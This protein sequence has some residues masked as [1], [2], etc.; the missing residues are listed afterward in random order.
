VGRKMKDLIKKILKEADFGWMDEVPSD[1]DLTLYKFLSDNS[2]I[3]VQKIQGIDGQLKRIVFLFDDVY[4]VVSSYQNKNDAFW[5]IVNMLIDNIDDF[6][7]KG[8]DENTKKSL[9]S[10]REVDWEKYKPTDLEPN[11]QRITKTIKKFLSDNLK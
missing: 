9:E 1:I 7:S 3:D 11:R 5:K 10:F 8:V 4:Y 6:I 2:E